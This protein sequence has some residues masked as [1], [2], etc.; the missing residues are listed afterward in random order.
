VKIEEPD[1][2]RRSRAP[3]RR[4]RRH[5]SFFLALNRSKKSVALDLKT[6]DG[7]TRCGG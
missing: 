5:R 7:A 3:G 4:S 2:R 6:A 1:A